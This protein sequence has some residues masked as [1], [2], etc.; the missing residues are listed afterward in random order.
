MNTGY[1][2][3]TNLV[4]TRTPD[5]NP[6]EIIVAGAGT[7]LNAHRHHLNL[8]AIVCG[9]VVFLAILAWYDVLQ[10]WLYESEANPSSVTNSKRIIFAV[11]CTIIAVLFAG[12]A[13]YYLH[14]QQQ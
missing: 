4:K 1:L 7:T 9:A 11:I 13:W 5:L 12:G 8:I 10:S 6:E 3:S 2:S 14:R